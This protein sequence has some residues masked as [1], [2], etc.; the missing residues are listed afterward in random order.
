MNLNWV[1]IRI[2]TGMD[3]DICYKLFVYLILRQNKISF[4]NLHTIHQ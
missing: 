4:D 2:L 3:L 1:K